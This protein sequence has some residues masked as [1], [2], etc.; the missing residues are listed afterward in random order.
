MGEGEEG[1]NHRHEA[2]Q[3]MSLQLGYHLNPHVNVSNIE[4]LIV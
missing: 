1:S 4:L 2:P 3:K